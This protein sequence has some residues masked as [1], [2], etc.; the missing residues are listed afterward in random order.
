[1][2]DV[3]VGF[4]TGYSFDR[5][6]PWVNSLDRCGFTGDKYMVCYDIDPSIVIELQSRGYKTVTGKLNPQQNIVL[7]RFHDLWH[8]FR[9]LVNEQYRYLITTDV[10]DVIFQDNPSTWLQ[11]NLGDKRI[12]VGC[13]SIRYCNEPWGNNNLNLS[14]GSLIHTRLKE[15][16]IGNAGTISGEF[17]TMLDLALN[18]Y[19]ICGRSPIF[20]PGGGGPDQAAL[21]VL[22]NSEPFKSITNLAMSESGY[23]AQLGTTGP[24]V[25]DKFGSY[26]VEPQPI[27]NEQSLVCTSTGIPFTIV[28]QYDRVPQWKEIIERKYE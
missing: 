17:N 3:V 20:V 15:C 22:I 2:K 27:L 21:N 5:I 1:M 13:E 6:K 24:Q 10:K 9:N 11:Q 26:L 4:I 18:I 12:N 25:T 23:A 14:F 28:H 19:L 16:L 8:I 7:T